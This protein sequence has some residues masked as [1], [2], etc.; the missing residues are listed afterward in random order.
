MIHRSND[1]PDLNSSAAAN[2]PFT[3][4]DCRQAPDLAVMVAFGKLQVR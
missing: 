4:I 3:G 2:F 1:S